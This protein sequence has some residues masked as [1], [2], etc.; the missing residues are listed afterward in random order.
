MNLIHQPTLHRLLAATLLGALVMFGVGINSLHAGESDVI[1]V[2]IE[3][4]GDGNFRINATVAHEDTGWDHY[5][6]RWD[7]L[8]EQGNVLGSRELAHPHVNEQPF[9]RSL[10]LSIPASVNT[11]TVR[12]NDSVHELGGKS[13]ELSVPHP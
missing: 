4:L 6:N 2:T 1:D 12:S 10:R 3:S 5:A 8:D 7:V 13:F 9:T 11:I